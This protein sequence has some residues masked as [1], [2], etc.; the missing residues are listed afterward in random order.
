VELA[1]FTASSNHLNA[2]LKWTTATEVNNEGFEIERRQIGNSNFEI[3]N[4][5]KIGFVSGSGTASSP[6]EYS[7][8]D[9]NLTAGRY[10][11]RISQVDRNGSSK[12]L[13]V[14][15]VEVGFAPRVF[16]LGQ[17]Y[18]NPFN[19]STTIEFT[20]P[21][22]GWAVLKVY[23]VIGREVATLVDGDLKAGVYQQAVFD[24]SRFASGVYF[25]RLQ[26]GGK[27]QLRKMALM[28]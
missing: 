16:S 3:R 13:S 5:S 10:A 12:Y 11:Y 6:H 24:A 22:D 18:P 2:E 26:F 27:Q 15:E 4:W 19:P 28:K 9:R 14:A 8:T 21:T 7:F 1:S 17:N 20:I 25:A 23:D